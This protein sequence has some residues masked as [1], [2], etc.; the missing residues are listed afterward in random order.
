MSSFFPRSWLAYWPLYSVVAG[1]LTT[2]AFAPFDY[3]WLVF[4]T[5]AAAFYLWENLSLKQA[6]LSGWLFGL[7]LQC[8]GVS[9]IYY[10]LHIHGG[11]PI[12]FAVILIFLLASYL[13]IY[14]ALAAY[15]VRRFLPDRHVLRLLLF[16]PASWLV[17]EWLQGYVMTGFAWMQLG[18]TQIDSSLSGFAP[19]LG[20]YAISGLVAVCAGTFVLLCEQLKNFRTEPAVFKNAFNLVSLLL[21]LFISGGLLKSINWTEKA[22]ELIKVSVVQGN[23]AQQEKWKMYMKQPTMDLYRE[24]SLAQNDVD[25]IV[26][27]ETAV[28]DYSYRIAPY[29]DNL[30]REMRARNTDLLLGVFVRSDEKRLYNSVLSLHGGVYS[31]RHLVPLGEYIPLRFLI[32]FFNSWVNIPMSDIAAAPQ[33]QP[34]IVAAGVPLG[35]SI[36]FEEA[37]SR[38]IIRDLPA[39]KVLV[40]VSN[41]AWFEDSN[42]AFQHHAIARM[43]ALETGRYMIRST[44]TGITSLIGPHGEVIKQL[45]QFVTEVLRGEVQPL[46]GA[47]PFVHWGDWLIVGISSLCLLA[48]AFNHRAARDR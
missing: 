38:D 9:W 39:A 13:C 46:S 10:S 43:R 16:Y 25:L 29:L 33:E 35:V 3:R 24:L 17:F 14:T 36:C 19:L 37:F 12:F 7:G 22:G 26:W 31:K 28:P 8:A 41:D 30:Q 27:P 4:V 6:T 42:E 5:L 2:L 40:N 11:T 48:F 34:L 21:F 1:A 32:E 23:I 18:Y 44:N 20:N 47:T 15:T 45:P